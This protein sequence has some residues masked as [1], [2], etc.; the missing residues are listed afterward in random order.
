MGVTRR[1]F[2]TG[3][4]TIPLIG[5]GFPRASAQNAAQDALLIG[6]NAVA[7]PLEL[8][9]DAYI[10]G[11]P[12]VTME[13]TRRVLT[14]VVAPEGKSA[15]MGQFANLRE[16]PDAKFRAV[17]APNADTLYSSAF[18]DV[19]REP[20]I[21]S[22]PNE[23]GRYFLMPMLSAWTNVFSVPG[24]RTTGTGPQTYFIAGPGWSGSVPSGAK[25]IQ[26]PTSLVWIIGR[27][28]CTGTP[29]DYKT[30]HALQDQYRLIPA[31]AAATSY[32]PPAGQVDPGIDTKTAVRE[33]VNN[34]DAAT[35]FN[36]LAALM[37][38]NPPALADGVAVAKMA[39]LGIVSGRT[40]DPRGL[41]PSVREAVEQAPKQAIS[42]IMGHMKTTGRHINGWTFTTDGGDYGKDYLQRALVTAVG[43]GCNLPQD[44]VYPL[45]TVDAAGRRLAGTSKYVMRFPAGELPPV[46]GF[47]SLTM[48]DANF[49]FVD[50][51]L[52]RYTVSPRNNLQTNPDGSVDLFIQTESPGP[53]RESNWLPA[54][55]GPFILMLRTYWPKDALLNGSWAPPP[56]TRGAGA[57]L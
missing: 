21:L 28:Y 11:Y 3:A 50:N 13:M 15:P 20:Y 56:V 44:A 7:D 2:A 5:S 54:P 45:T 41:T 46:D 25:L 8:A 30:V 26:A 53:Q 40:F 19:G 6:N 57:A 14:N 4:A 32:T 33:Q 16:Y 48:Y 31:S 34:L 38:D 24:K 39:S 51:P 49:F 29:E 55:T 27:T 35:Y 36:L 17:T 12:L 43:L 52:N 23:D 47:W 18:L 10:Y 42:R 22:I 1:I 37:K 9:T